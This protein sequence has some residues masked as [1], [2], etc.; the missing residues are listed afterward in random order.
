MR[1]RMR[2]RELCIEKYKR[3]TRYFHERGA[4]LAALC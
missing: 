3:A 4:A 1:T 2:E